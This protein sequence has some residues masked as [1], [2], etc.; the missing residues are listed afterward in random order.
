[1]IRI[2]FMK[3]QVIQI[4]IKMKMILNICLNVFKIELIMNLKFKL[5]PILILFKILSTKIIKILFITYI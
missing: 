4:E 2:F 5:L 3:V 1:M